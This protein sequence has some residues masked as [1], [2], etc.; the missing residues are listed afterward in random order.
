M[1]TTSATARA[2]RRSATRKI[3]RRVASHGLARQEH[4]GVDDRHALA[5]DQRDAEQI[6][7]GGLD[8]VDPG[9]GA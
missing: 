4:A 8:A 2:T 7:R 3:T 9:T 1:P 6:G 5:S